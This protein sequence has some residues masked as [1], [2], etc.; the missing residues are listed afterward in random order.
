LEVKKMEAKKFIVKQCDKLHRIYE[1]FDRVLPVEYT[2][3]AAR[4][5]DYFK[6]LP[7]EALEK[8]DEGKDLYATIHHVFA[9]I[10]F[11]L[12][13]YCA[14]YENGSVDKDCVGVILQKMHCELQ[15]HFVASIDGL[16]KLVLG[17]GLGS[18]L[19]FDGFKDHEL[20]EFI[21]SYSLLRS[22]GKESQESADDL[23]E[24][25]TPRLMHSDPRE[26]SHKLC[27]LMEKVRREGDL[28]GAIELGEKF[29]DPLMKL[30]FVDSRMYPWGRFHP[31]EAPY[32]EAAAGISR[33]LHA[34]YR[35]GICDHPGDRIH[36]EDGYGA[37]EKRSHWREEIKKRMEEKTQ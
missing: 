34:L 31:K 29:Y 20:S 9:H 18:C 10:S 12:G 17:T 7:W 16:E 6:D 2:D 13:M 28:V 26:Y 35:K 37:G 1:R 25:L 23:I 3:V 27:D 15:K 30:I 22:V 5:L 14:A 24:Q 4:V 8:T 32:F 11:P 33:K 21:S 36:W 19:I